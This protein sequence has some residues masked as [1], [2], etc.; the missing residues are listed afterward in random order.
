[1][2]A[3]LVVADPERKS[4]TICLAVT[5]AMKSLG[6]RNRCRVFEIPRGLDYITAPPRMRL[7]L[8]YSAKIYSIYLD[9]FSADDIHVYSV[10]EV[11]IDATTYLGFYH[12]DAH[13]FAR[14][15]VREVLRETGITATCGIGTICTKP[16][17]LVQRNLAAPHVREITPQHRALDL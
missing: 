2:T 17:R 13:D 4:G 1:M 11:F 14:M 7:Y 10:D 8:E 9:F 3:R 5:P 16:E 12:L 6:V 15:L